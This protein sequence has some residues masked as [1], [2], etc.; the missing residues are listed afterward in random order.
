MQN[1]KTGV[2]LKVGF[3]LI[4]KD[5]QRG[6]EVKSYRTGSII[7]QYTTGLYARPSFWEGLARIFDFG[8]SLNTYNTS[9]SNEEADVTALRGD[10]EE[11]GADMRRAIDTWEKQHGVNDEK[12]TTESQSS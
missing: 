1:D 11:V 3:K 9:R 2:S 10:W 4:F 12:K 8:G 7:G 5:F 6:T